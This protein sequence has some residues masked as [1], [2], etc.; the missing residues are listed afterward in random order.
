MRGEITNFFILIFLTL[1][2]T[3]MHE[4]E[5]ALLSNPFLGLK[6]SDSVKV[7]A[8]NIISTDQFEYNGT[9]SPDGSEFYYTVNLPNRGQIVF[10][11]LREDNTWTEPRFAEFSSKFSEV[12]PI[13]SPDGMR[14]YFTSNR[15]ISESADLT[16]NNIWYV[17]RTENG[18]SKPQYVALTESGDY[19]SSIT[20]NGDIYFNTG[21]G[22]IF[23]AVKTDSIHGIERLPDVINLNKSVADPFISPDEDYLIF[24]GNNLEDA[25]GITD[26]YI[27]FKVNNEWT[28]PL[29]LGEPI[30]SNARE[31]SPYITANGE[32]LIFAS[33]RLLEEFETQGLQ[34]ISSYMDKS[35][36]FDN[37]R[38]NI[39][40]TS[41]TFIDKL[42]VKAVINR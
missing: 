38:W 12:D 27:S 31:M 39:F 33:N 1:G 34:P 15:P 26:L 4:E 18:W 6:V 20:S 29:N 36:S 23:K 10:L 21:N 9:F 19:Y 32:F 40:F 41:T 3:S 13:F 17:E 24:R 42:R 8:P 5:R 7:L 22:D 25:I 14:L 35:Q 28:E 30:N 2:C 11:E 37:G 16:R